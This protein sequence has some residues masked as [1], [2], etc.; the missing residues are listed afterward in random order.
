MGLCLFIFSYYSIIIITEISKELFVD[1]NV[2]FL[3][4]DM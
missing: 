4:I 2:G 1:M 3:K